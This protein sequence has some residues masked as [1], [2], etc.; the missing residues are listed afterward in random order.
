MNFSFKSLKFKAILLM[1]LAFISI[2]LI[3]ILGAFMMSIES[4]I[5]MLKFILFGVSLI[6]V[7]IISLLFHFLI[8]S[9]LIPIDRVSKAM[10]K[11]AEG[12][13]KQQL[14]ISGDNEIGAM[15]RS[16]NL[17][18]QNYYLPTTLLKR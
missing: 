6:C 17:L 12:D 10:E 14:S 9:I 4:H 3:I 16:F 5:N 2:L 8:K 7:T 11:M 13:F 1:L 15:E 18:S